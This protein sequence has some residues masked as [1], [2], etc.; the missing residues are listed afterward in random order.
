[1]GITHKNENSIA[2]DHKSKKPSKK[3][4]RTT[5]RILGYVNAMTPQS[6]LL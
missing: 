5:P 1:V 4:N 3:E 2:D 6:F